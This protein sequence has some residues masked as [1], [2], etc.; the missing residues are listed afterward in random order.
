MSVSNSNSASSFENQIEV[1]KFL[2][3]HLV[4]RL[5]E[6]SLKN[7]TIESD[8]E[9]FLKYKK[10]VL[11]KTFL[12]DDQKKFL[13]S[14][15][16]LVEEADSLSIEQTQENL[17]KKEDL[18]KLSIIG[19]LNLME[20]YRRNP[21]FDM[22]SSISKKIVD[23]TSVNKVLEYSKILY[24]KGNYSES[25]T[26]LSDFFRFS[27]ENKKNLSRTILAL[28]TILSI[29]ILDNNWTEIFS[30]F[31]HI[32]VLIE[33]LKN[34]LEEEFKKTNTESVKLNFI[35]HKNRHNFS[36]RRFKST[37]NIFFFSEV[38]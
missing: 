23:E 7:V 29:N 30:N 36:Q 37:S 18:S 22:G 28:W 25:K 19:F 35:I 16:N 24:E 1:L 34:N 38:T 4:I 15:Q 32:K 14:N 5:L 3:P 26:L 27:F 13:D 17:K 8:K 11:F 31:S 12:F 6:F 20:N 21:N 33:L 10:K 2:D 9:K